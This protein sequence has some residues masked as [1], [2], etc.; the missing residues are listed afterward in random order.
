M[1]M[2]YEDNLKTGLGPLGQSCATVKRPNITSEPC[3]RLSC[4][5]SEA[6]RVKFNMARILQIPSA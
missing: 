2:T 1:L 5:V 4:F 6:R 3:L